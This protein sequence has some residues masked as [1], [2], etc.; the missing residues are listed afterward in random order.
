M[1]YKLPTTFRTP[2]C[3]GLTRELGQ[4]SEAVPSSNLPFPLYLSS[5]PIPLVLSQD[6]FFMAWEKKCR[7]GLSLPKVAVRGSHTL[8]ELFCARLGEKP[9][10]GAGDKIMSAARMF[11]RIMYACSVP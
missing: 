2:I 6:E 10:A 7:N 5:M 9:R 11:S 1:S 8:V 4:E 3:G